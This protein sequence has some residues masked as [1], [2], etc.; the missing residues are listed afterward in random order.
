MKLKL[1]SIPNSEDS[2]KIKDFLIQ[3][4]LK[5]EEAIFD[6]RV[7]SELTNISSYL[8]NSQE[9]FLIIRY[10]SAIHAI[11]GFNAHAFDQLFKHIKKYKPKIQ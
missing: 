2:R 3:H 6:E 4:N 11:H 8:K 5:F 1:Y 9:S 10:S 7:Y